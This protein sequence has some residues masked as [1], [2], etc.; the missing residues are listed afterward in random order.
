M[1]L[2][3][4]FENPSLNVQTE[5]DW[6]LISCSNCVVILEEA[7]VLSHAFKRFNLQAAAALLFRV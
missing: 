3:N 5:T 2:L 7:K 1:M 6:K 4:T